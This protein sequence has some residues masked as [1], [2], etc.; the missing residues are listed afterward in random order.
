[1]NKNIPIIVLLTLAAVSACSVLRSEADNSRLNRNINV[2]TGDRENG[3]RKAVDEGATVTGSTGKT[4]TG[5]L[6]DVVSLTGDFKFKAPCDLSVE[7]G[8]AE[9]QSAAQRKDTQT[10]VSNKVKL[11]VISQKSNA[12]LTAEFAE[13]KRKPAA[14]K[15]E[16]NGI[17]FVEYTDARTTTTKTETAGFPPSNEYDTQITKNKVY[18]VNDRWLIN[19]EASCKSTEKNYCEN[20]FADKSG[21][22]SVFFASL[23]MLK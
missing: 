17:P 7:Q 5:V 11:S 1:M 13:L 22:V 18:L 19:F 15:G 23:Q 2:K 3:D 9:K 12:D 21:T 8:D 14:G 4:E 10:C 16:H 20:I 6:K